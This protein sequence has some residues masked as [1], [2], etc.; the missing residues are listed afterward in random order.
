MPLLIVDGSDRGSDC[1]AYAESLRGGFTRVD[2]VGW[3]IGHGRGMDYGI[4]RVE[5]QWLLIF[6]SDVVILESPLVQML[7]MTDK[8]TYG[9]GWVYEVGRDGFD[10]GTPNR[11]H[12]EPIP[13]LHP[14]FM[15]LSTWQYRRFAPFVH[16]GAPCYKAMVDI[17][18]RG[19]SA[20][21]LKHFTGLT[22]HTSGEGINWVGK[23]SRYVRHDFGGTRSNNKRN[24][25]DEIIGV[26]QK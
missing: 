26:W 8:E 14:Y 21:V 1:W 23:P 20:R 19:L 25:Q 22:G 13:Y 10:Y 6:D 12:T 16:H 18:D 24:G 15:L 7:A 4:S 17:Y 5:T 9:V 2:H 11:G 3:N